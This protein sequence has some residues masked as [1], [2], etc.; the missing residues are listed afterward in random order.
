LTKV[1]VV[2]GLIC[3]CINE[4]RL[5]F[6]TCLAQNVFVTQAGAVNKQRWSV[7]FS[8]GTFLIFSRLV[9]NSQYWSWKTLRIWIMAKAHVEGVLI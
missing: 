1:R 9:G 4:S 8:G 2:V 3:S 6:G 5:S 7:I